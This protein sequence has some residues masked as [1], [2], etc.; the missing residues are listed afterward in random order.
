MQATNTTTACAPKSS[1]VPVDEKQPRT[2]AKAAEAMWIYYRDHKDLL[3][4]DIKEYR[5]CI[6][7]KLVA[8]E[9]V[10]QVFAPYAR[11]AVVPTGRPKK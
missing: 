2:D 8:G 9:P 4:T 7:A 10:E 6:L 1:N 11:P 3:L 5:D